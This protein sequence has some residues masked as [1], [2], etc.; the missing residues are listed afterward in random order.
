MKVV[1]PPEG[2]NSEGG[3][4]SDVKMSGEMIMDAEPK[5]AL[6]PPAFPEDA[7]SLK[8]SVILPMRIVVGADGSVESVTLRPGNF[9]VTIPYFDKLNAEV[10]KASRK[11]EFIPARVVFIKPDGKGGAAYAGEK[12]AEMYFDVDFTFDSSK[13]TTVDARK[14]T[15]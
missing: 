13:A 12:R 11:W 2:A 8:G 7:K 6:V 9:A 15:R 14:K 5:E 3:D 1:A 4:M 10:Q